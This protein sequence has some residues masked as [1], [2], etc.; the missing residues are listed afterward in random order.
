MRAKGIITKKE[1]RS[2]RRSYDFLLRARN[3]L[4]YL[5]GRRNDVLSFEFQEPVARFLGITDCP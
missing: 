4:H 2:L 3:E 5:S 1:Y